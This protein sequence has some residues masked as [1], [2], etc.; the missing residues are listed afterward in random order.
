MLEKTLE[1]PLDCEEI[2]LVH[3]KGNQSWIFI[4]RTDAKAKAPILWLADVK[5]RVIRK[6]SDAGKDWSQE[7]K[8]TT[9][10]EMVG[11][12]HQSY[13]HEFEQALGVGDK[14]GSLVCCSPWGRKESHRTE[15]LNWTQ[16]KDL[17]YRTGKSVH[18]YLAA[19]TRGTF[20]RE[21]I[22]VSIWLRPFSVY[23]K[24]SHF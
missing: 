12:H 9:E 2:K 8:G 17:L 11:W 23:L 7:E 4:G 15:W 20:G 16:Q 10:N 22:C 18:C 19:W 21:W 13:G 24:L 6:E 5:K 1:C 3:S 14:Q